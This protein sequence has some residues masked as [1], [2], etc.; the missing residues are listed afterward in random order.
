M[1]CGSDICQWQA[2]TAWTNQNVVFRALPSG[3]LFQWVP[4]QGWVGLA[5]GDFSR[6]LPSALAY[7]PASSSNLSESG[8]D[9][10]GRGWGVSNFDGRRT[11]GA[12]EGVLHCWR[13]QV[14]E[15]QEVQQVQGVHR[16]AAGDLWRRSLRPID[17][18]VHTYMQLQSRTPLPCVSCLSVRS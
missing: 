6:L 11:L 14:Q 4:R 13:S 2:A 3:S 17:H 9:R 5:A 7:C 12:L 16:V 8:A 10:E 15:V 18:P 1:S